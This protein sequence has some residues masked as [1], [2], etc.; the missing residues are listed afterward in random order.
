MRLSSQNQSSRSFL[1]MKLAGH[2]GEAE[3]SQG[4]FQGGR[5]LFYSMSFIRVTSST[6]PFIV[7]VSL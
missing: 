4:M 6:S 2:L 5:S 1:S 3:M 7:P